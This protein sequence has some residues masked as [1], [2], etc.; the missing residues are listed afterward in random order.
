VPLVIPL[1]ARRA[2]HTTPRAKRLGFAK[3]WSCLRPPNLSSEDSASASRGRE[4][5]RDEVARQRCKMR[6]ECQRDRPHKCLRI[7]V[8][9]PGRQRSPPGARNNFHSARDVYL[10][11]HSLPASFRPLFAIY[12]RTSRRFTEISGELLPFVVV[13]LFDAE[14]GVKSGPRS[15]SG[16]QFTLQSIETFLVSFRLSGQWRPPL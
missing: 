2:G 3:D 15:V 14:K 8:L 1:R 6:T 9:R 10:V 7:R 16:C 12:K 4:G 13:F 5:S 11:L